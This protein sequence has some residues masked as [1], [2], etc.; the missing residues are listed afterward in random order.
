MPSRP[1]NRFPARLVAL[2]FRVWLGLVLAFIFSPLI[3]VAVLSFNKSPYGMLPFEFSTE[4][5]RRLF[6][7]KELLSATWLDVRLSLAV[8]AAAALVGTLLAL[9]LVRSSSSRFAAFLEMTMVSAVT[10]PWLILGIGMLLVL[11]QIGLGRSQ[12]SMFLGCLVVSLPY[13]VFIV[14][15]RL[16]T[17]D[18]S[19][20]E[21]A[22]ALGAGPIAV[23]LRITMPLTGTAIAAGT[24]MAFI[25][26]FNNFIIQYL[27]A[28]LGIR[29]LPL[30][31]Y[32]MVRDGYRPDINALGTILVVMAIILVLVLQWITGN[33]SR[34]IAGA[35]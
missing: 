25:T 33:A 12:I 3:I 16:G 34:A 24:L 28:P 31:I 1:S 19:L 32:A 20:G 6:D 30:E 9:W 27:L 4:W 13:V 2:L 14:K 5:Y 22:R 35:R 29:T 8:A 11:R 10:I 21:A 23:F 7:T 18:P 26:T 17:L 15:T